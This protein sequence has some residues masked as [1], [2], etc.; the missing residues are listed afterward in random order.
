[1]FI[2]TSENYD[3]SSLSST[4]PEAWLIKDNAGFVS[5]VGKDPTDQDKFTLTFERDL[6]PPI[7]LF[8]YTPG[9][10]AADDDGTLF[11]LQIIPL[12]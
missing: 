11:P 2:Q 9:V 6:E 1:M 10:L 12:V 7:G 8:Q 5:A 3:G 4:S